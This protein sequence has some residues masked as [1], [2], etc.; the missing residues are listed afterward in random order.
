[1]CGLRQS[2]LGKDKVNAV[3]RLFTSFA[4]KGAHINLSAAYAFVDEKSS[5]R[6]G[7]R[8]RHP[9]SFACRQILP[10]GIGSQLQS[11]PPLFAHSIG[12]V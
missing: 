6:K 9:P 2:T 10:T 7:T 12:E 11:K 1:M 8:Q 5:N 4:A 3:D